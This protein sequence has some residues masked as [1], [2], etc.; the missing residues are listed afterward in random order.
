[1]RPQ[2]NTQNKIMAQLADLQLKP[3]EELRA[4]WQDLFNKPAPRCHKF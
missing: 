1:M 3:T 2:Q 4:Q